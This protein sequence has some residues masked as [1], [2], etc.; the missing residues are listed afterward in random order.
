[1]LLRG[2]CSVCG[3]SGIVRRDGNMWTHI[4]LKRRHA[5]PPA[6]N[7]QTFTRRAEQLI[8]ALIPGASPEKRTEAIRIVH[9][10]FGEQLSK[11]QD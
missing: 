5:C 10:T 8:D 3:R 4:C 6:A 2:Y 11:E 9:E 7:I 1:M